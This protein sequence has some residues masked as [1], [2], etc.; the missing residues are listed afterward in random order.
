MY[1]FRSAVSVIAANASTLGTELEI[2]ACSSCMTMLNGQALVAAS[3][4]LN[5]SVS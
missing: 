3:V 5:S 1:S 4:G 2:I